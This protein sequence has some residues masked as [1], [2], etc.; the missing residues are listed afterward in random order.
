MK[1]PNK[2][3]FGET[4]E[5]WLPHLPEAIHFAIHQGLVLPLDLIDVVDVAGVQVLL[6]H[7]AQ[8]AVVWGVSW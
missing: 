2:R 8:E 7:E 5:L 3:L 1:S 4:G 6:H